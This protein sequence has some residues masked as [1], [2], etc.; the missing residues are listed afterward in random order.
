MGYKKLK[1]RLD[2]LG[3]EPLLIS[4]D[5]PERNQRFREK[6]KIP[7]TLL[8]DVDHAVADLYGIPISR[9]QRWAKHYQDGFIQPAVFVYRGDTEVFTFVQTPKMTNLWGAARRPKPEQVLDAAE[10]AS[11]A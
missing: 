6:L 11:V 5:T 4:A 10:K 3:I 9:K 1:P 7:F 8:S 2:A